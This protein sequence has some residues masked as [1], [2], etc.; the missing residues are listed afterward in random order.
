MLDS[1]VATQMP[2]KSGYGQIFRTGLLS[3]VISVG[4]E[5]LVGLRKSVL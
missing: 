3:H 4:L 5:V 1:S 2:E